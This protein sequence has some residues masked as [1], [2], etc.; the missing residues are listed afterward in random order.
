MRGNDRE[1]ALC[2]GTWWGDDF[3][4]NK[5]D[6][7]G[8]H[9]CLLIA[10]L[11]AYTNPMISFLWFFKWWKVSMQLYISK[12]ETMIIINKV[13]SEKNFFISSL[14]LLQIQRWFIKTKHAEGPLQIS[15]R[16][17]NDDLG[18]KD[19]YVGCLAVTTRGPSGWII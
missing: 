8:S 13:W 15:L 12:R 6:F 16:L 17:V 7:G 5:Y 1:Y 19:L 18:N 14:K 2:Y 4:Y 11:L 10:L 3:I 9:I